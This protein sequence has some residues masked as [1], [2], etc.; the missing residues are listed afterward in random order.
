M[1]LIAMPE[2][3][4]LSKLVDQVD[5][6]GEPITLTRGGQPVVDIVPHQ[7]GQTRGKSQQAVVQEL[8]HLR[9]TL[10]KSSA[11]ELQETI[12]EGRR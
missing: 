8:D 9:A 12:E 5:Q 7:R 1:R 6:T 4:E 10:P 3:S 11:A 2:P